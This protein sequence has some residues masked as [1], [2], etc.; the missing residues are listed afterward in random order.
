MG[1][2]VVEKKRTLKVDV[3]NGQYYATNGSVFQDQIQKGL[4]GINPQWD[5]LEEPLLLYNQSI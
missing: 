4:N 2:C 1:R 5:Q 3:S